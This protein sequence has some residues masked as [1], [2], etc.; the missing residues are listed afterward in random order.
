MTEQHSDT[1]KE[2]TILDHLADLRSCLLR[3][4]VA[5]IL[6]ALLAYYFS[7]DIFEILSKPFGDAFQGANLIGTG[8]AEAFILK[9]K[10]SLFS[11]L[12]FA[13]PIIFFEIW[14]FISPGLY[15]AERRLFLPFILATTALFI[16]GVAF[17][18]FVVM[19]FAYQFFNAQY[20]SVGVA[21]TIR[22]SEHLALLVRA[23]IGF[24]AVF[25]LPVL[26]YFLTRAGIIDAEMLTGGI[27]YAIVVSFIVAAVLTPPDVLT[28]FLMAGPLILLYGLS[29]LVAKVARRDSSTT[30]E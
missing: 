3:S 5:V 25:E 28:Q 8:P 18:F 13:A 6:A 17:C 23:M 15:P 16:A 9:L 21:P 29:I 14:R 20:K 11:G 22:I 2:M 19:P 1:E 26:S 24:G 27:R 4:F 30:A 7:T 10:V 12:L